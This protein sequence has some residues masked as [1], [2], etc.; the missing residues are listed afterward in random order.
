MSPPQ[1]ATIDILSLKDVSSIFPSIFLYP[2][3]SQLT[4]VVLRNYLY[5]LKGIHKQILERKTESQ[6][7]DT[8]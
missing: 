4:Q 8:F 2:L 1:K 6:V 7:L 3:L 5:L